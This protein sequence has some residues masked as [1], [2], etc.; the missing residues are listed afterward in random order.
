MAIRKTP[1]DTTIQLKT[2]QTK[3]PKSSINERNE[4]H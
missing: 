3:A 1:N 4:T 2:A